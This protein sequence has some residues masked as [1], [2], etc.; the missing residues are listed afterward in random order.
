MPTDTVEMQVVNAGGKVRLLSLHDLDRRTAAYRRTVDLIEQI[1]TDAGGHDRL[2][3]GERQIIQR[4]ALTCALAEHLEARWLSGEEIDP[5][6]YCTLANAQKRLLESVGLR[7]VP[8]DVAPSLTDY[9]R[10]RNA[11]PGPSEATP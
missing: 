10:S 8:R 6:L 1:E 5:V 4:I 2:S 11:T 7:R 3:T 9:L